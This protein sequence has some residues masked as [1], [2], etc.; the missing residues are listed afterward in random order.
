[1]S[2][3]KKWG[4]SRNQWLLAIGI[5]VINIPRSI[6]TMSVPIS[7]DPFRFAVDLGAGLFGGYITIRVLSGI[8]NFFRKDQTKD[9]GDG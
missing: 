4:L 6:M 3:D 9:D 7:Q 1:M 2:E 8:W 5:F